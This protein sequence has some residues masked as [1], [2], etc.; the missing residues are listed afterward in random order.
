MK[1]RDV[2]R[3]IADYF[4]Y[5]DEPGGLER[6]EQRVFQ[7]NKAGRRQELRGMACKGRGRHEGR[8]N[9]VESVGRQ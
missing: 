4:S 5:G 3:A 2:I 8:K 7:P 9:K 6:N 1:A